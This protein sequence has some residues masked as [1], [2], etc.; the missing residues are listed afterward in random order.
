[1]YH[2][3]RPGTVATS[4]TASTPKLEVT[5]SSFKNIRARLSGGA[6]YINN[7]YLIE[8]KFTTCIFTNIQAL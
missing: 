3:K 6:F 2:V 5:T 4:I 1:M 8:A 7:P